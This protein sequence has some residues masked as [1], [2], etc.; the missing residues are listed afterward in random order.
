MTLSLN[1]LLRD[2]KRI[3]R[4]FF[5]LSFLILGAATF[6]TQSRGAIIGLFTSIIFLCL[7]EKKLL[8]LVVLTVLVVLILPGLRERFSFS[9]LVRSERMQIN[10]LTMEVIKEHPLTGIGFGME[11]YGN[12]DLVDLKKLNS[13][14]PAPYQQEKIILSPHNTILDVAARTGIIGGVL[15]LSILFAACLLLWK[16]LRSPG[17]EY[18]RSWAIC[19]TACLASF[20]APALFA[21][22]AFGPQAV[23][24]YTILAMI[25]ILWNLSRKEKEAV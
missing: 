22:T 13:R 9:N 25:T 7:A 8:I 5:L 18:F 16:I 19:L 17:D 4:I 1:N 15:F 23:A 21:D 20:L 24:F 3:W 10:R 14:L 2:K 12:K 11:I 6:L